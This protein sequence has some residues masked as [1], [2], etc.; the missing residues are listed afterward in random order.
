M[1]KEKY[2]YKHQDSLPPDPR[3]SFSDWTNYFKWFDMFGVQPQFEIKAQKKY[4]SC[5]GIIGSIACLWF[6]LSYAVFKMAF[7]MRDTQF[8]SNMLEG[9]DSLGMTGQEL[10]LELEFAQNP[11]KYEYSE[12]SLAKF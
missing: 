6:I 1:G 10:D 7:M 3:P 9:F 5:C 4:K 8:G 11:G 12:W 2:S